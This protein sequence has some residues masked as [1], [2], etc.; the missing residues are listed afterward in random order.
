MLLKQATNTIKYLLFL[1]KTVFLQW[2]IM[3]SIM[4]Q[5]FATGVAGGFHAILISGL[6]SNNSDIHATRDEAFWIGKVSHPKNNEPIRDDFRI[7]NPTD[8]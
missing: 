1:Y 8:L 6:T 3:C 7:Q 5:H 4:F 2:Y